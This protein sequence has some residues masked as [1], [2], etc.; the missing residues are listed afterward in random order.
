M[1]KLLLGKH[2]LYWHPD[3]LLKFMK[4]EIFPPIN[5]E[6]SPSSRCNQRCQHCYTAFTMKPEVSPDFI[7][8][9][10]FLKAIKDCADFGVKTVIMCGAGEPLLHPLTP[11]AISYAKKLGL[12]VSMATNG[13]LATKN[14]MESCLGDL[15]YLRVSM[16]G[17]SPKRY[18][19]LQGSTEKA[20]FQVMDNLKDLVEIKRKKKLDTTLGVAYPLFE[21]C[22]DD[23][24]PFVTKLRDIGVDYVQLKPCG[25]FKK[26]EYVYKKD[27]YR[28]EDVVEKLKEAEKLNSDDFYCQVKY[29]RFRWAEEAEHAGIPEKCWGLLI[30]TSVGSDGKVYTCSGSWYSQRDCYGSLE[31]NTLKEIW[32]S[33]KFK[34]VFERRSI[35]DKEQ[36]F[37]QCRNIIMNSFLMELKNPPEHVNFV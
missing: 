10:L 5:V 13:A 14:R 35:V 7:D 11:H 2:K 23:I 6:L 24:V 21:G 30:Y 12:D 4:G 22:K 3:V 17:G 8:D 37:F 26:N 20:F 19:Q 18:A 25:D 27:V 33:E 9:K 15:S 36:C 31:K 32:M 1:A 16:S 29:D 34:E 28:D